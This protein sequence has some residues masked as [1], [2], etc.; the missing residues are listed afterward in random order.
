MNQFEEFI[1]AEKKQ[2]KPESNHEFRQYL[3]INLRESSDECLTL[4]CDGVTVELFA[5][6]WWRKQ[7]LGVANI[8]NIG[9]GGIGLVSATQLEIGQSIVIEFQGHRLKLEVARNWPVNNRLHFSGAKWV[10]QDENEIINMID[11]ITKRN[12]YTPAGI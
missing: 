11:L 6:N 10:T 9:L 1:P 7:R 4:A 5:D 3:R 8:K 2:E 12:T